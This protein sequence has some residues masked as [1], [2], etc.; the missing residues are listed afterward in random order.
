[1]TIVRMVTIGFALTLGAC[2]LSGMPLFSAPSSSAPPSESEPAYKELILKQLRNI[3]PQPVSIEYIA[4]SGLLPGQYEDEAAWRVCLMAYLKES[5]QNID[6]RSETLIIQNGAVVAWR[7][8]SPEDG[9]DRQQLV[10]LP[11]ARK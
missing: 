9:C 2:G 11:I 10:S 7:A 3:F 4:V 8:A 5:S 1:M 6:Y